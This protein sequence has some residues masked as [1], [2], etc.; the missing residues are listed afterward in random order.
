MYTYSRGIWVDEIVILF[1]GTARIQD[2][3]VISA[4]DAAQVVGCAIVC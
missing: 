2:A 1:R 3:K 4:S